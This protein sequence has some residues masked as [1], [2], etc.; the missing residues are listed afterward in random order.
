MRRIWLLRRIWVTIAAR[1]FRV[2]RIFRGIG[3][4]AHSWGLRDDGTHGHR[5]GG[6]TYDPA[7]PVLYYLVRKAPG[8]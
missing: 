4:L 8:A 7:A 2:S 3:T 1:M 5:G 6:S